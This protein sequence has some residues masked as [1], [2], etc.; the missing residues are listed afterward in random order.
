[1]STIFTGNKETC[2]ALKKKREEKTYFIRSGFGTG[3]LPFALGHSSAALFCRT[4]RYGEASILTDNN[5]SEKIEITSE[6]KITIV[7]YIISFV[8]QQ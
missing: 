3:E 4:D 7:F 5:I 6:R 1:L 2:I 8:K